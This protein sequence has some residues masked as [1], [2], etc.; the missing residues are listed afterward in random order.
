MKNLRLTTCVLR[1]GFVSVFSIIGA[2][3]GAQQ[4]DV[5]SPVVGEWLG[6]L[7]AGSL[8]LRLG[9]SIRARPDGSLEGDVDSFDQGALNLPADSVRL[10]GDTL[11]MVLVQIRARYVG[12]LSADRRSIVGAWIQGGSLPLTLARADSA[13]IAAAMPKRP[14]QPKPPFPYRDQ[15][16]VI[17]SVPG[18]RLSGTLSLPEGRG[19]HPGVILVSGSGPQDRDETLLG[20]K[21]FLVLADHLARRGI[22]VL[23]YDDR[24]FGKSTGTFGTA[25]S[26]DFAADARAA[27]TYLRRRREVKR[28][29]VG[30]VGHSEGG[31]IAPMV[32]RDSAAGVG[33]VVLL[34]GP[35]LPGDEIMLAQAELIG[36]VSGVSDSMRMRSAAAARRSYAAIRE[37]RDTIGLAAR[38]RLILEDALSS[39]SPAERTRLGLTDEG[40]AQQAAMLTS[41]WFRYFLTYD[42]RPALRALRVPVLALNGV[43]DLQVPHQANLAAI[44]AALRAGHNPPAVIDSL[45]GLNH[46]FQTAKTGGPQEY[47]RIDETFAP[48]V[49]ERISSWILKTGTRD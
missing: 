6:T 41:P 8:T 28:N 10:T 23:R 44:R 37:A 40:I 42:P 17:Q 31:L 43:L 16:V 47:S 33:F 46:L 7:S 34:A 19:P 39:L 27:V 18:V 35:G 45:P 1:L 38:V 21:P 12:V 15:E 48:A 3:M 14:Q 36:R 32:A 30:L 26:A 22:A 25:T 2:P 29:A 13:A 11:R 4:V 20:H 5:R 24:G 9:F 49:L